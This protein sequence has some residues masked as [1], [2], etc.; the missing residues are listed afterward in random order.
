M[1]WITYASISS[2]H[3]LEAHSFTPGHQV[4][5]EIVGVGPRGIGEVLLIGGLYFFH[6]LLFFVVHGHQLA[7]GLFV[8][9]WL[10]HGGSGS[11]F[12]QFHYY[13]GLLVLADVGV[14]RFLAQQLL[15][16]PPHGRILGIQILTSR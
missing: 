3:V 4:V 13:F 14:E 9:W 1:T 8:D 2:F 7:F 15:T 10:P 11:A 16:G 5:F 6:L 12:G